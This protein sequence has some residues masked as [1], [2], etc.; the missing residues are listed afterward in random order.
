MTT[1]NANRKILDM[2]RWEL[3]NP[4]PNAGIGTASCF[5]MCDSVRQL[6]L[7][8]YTQTQMYLYDVAEDGFHQIQSSGSGTTQAAGAAMCAIPWSYGPGA[9]SGSIVGSGGTTSTITTGQTINRDLRGWKIH[10]LEGPNAGATLDI[11]SSTPGANAT[12]TVP[13]QASAFTGATRFRL[14]TPRYYYWNGTSA[15]RDFRMYDYA[16]NTWYPCSTTGMPTTF[17]TDAVLTSTPSWVGDDY[18]EFATGTAT[19]G[20]STTLVNSAKTWTVNQWVNFQVRIVSGTGA[21]QYRTISANDATSV[22]VSIAWAITP[23]STSVYAIEGNDNFLYLIGNNAVTMYRYSITTDTWTTLTPTVARAAAAAGG[24]S[25]L[26]VRDSD[27]PKWTDESAIIN[28]RRLYSMRGGNSSAVDYYDI[29][30]NSWV[31]LPN[32]TTTD[33]FNINNRYVLIKDKIYASVGGSSTPLRWVIFNILKNHQDPWSTAPVLANTSLG[34]GNFG[35][36]GYYK[37]G[38]TVINYVY[39]A[40]SN[41]SFLLRCMVI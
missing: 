23:D 3:L 39:A 11:V 13:T 41:G 20:T 2:K 19:S 9:N 24:C 38:T 10:I 27:D 30:S 22:T 17:G 28:G 5:A 26:W 6:A 14:L 40:A 7:Y 29:P 4:L 34:S 31:A 33:A 12:I 16:F 25:L 18:A 1:T 36:R 32:V 21:G 8:N 37:D 15:A 35:F